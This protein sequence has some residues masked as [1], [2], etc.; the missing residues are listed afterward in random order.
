MP[1]RRVS[2]ARKSISSFVHRHSWL[3]AA[4]ALAMAA[5]FAVALSVHAGGLIVFALAAGTA[6]TMFAWGYAKRASR[7]TGWAPLNHLARRQYGQVWDSLMASKIPPRVAE[8]DV[9]DEEEMGPS[10]AQ[11]L[12]NLTTLAGVS[13]HDDVLEIGCGAGRIGIGAAPLCRT[14]TGADISARMLALASDRL[15][16]LP[17][18]TLVQLSSVSLVEFK[19]DS[20]DVVYCTS[21]FGHLDEMD[22][23]QYIRE[24]CRV[25]RSGGRLLVDNINVES[26]AGWQGFLKQASQYQDIE[27]PPFLPRFSTAAELSNYVARAGFGR[28]HVALQGGLIVVTATKRVASASSS[29]EQFE[30]SQQHFW[31]GREYAVGKSDRLPRV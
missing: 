15:R 10:T 4:V 9:S 24:A 29:Q 21:V 19:D 13:R 25:L 22:R 26:D 8:Q 23:W 7:Q 31:R 17:N 6:A 1:V 16:T 28:A 5:S 18:V 3:P 12:E 14:W 2:A 20:F 30:I 11:C 27:R